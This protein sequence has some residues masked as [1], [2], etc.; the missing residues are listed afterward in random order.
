MLGE[1]VEDQRGAVDDL[2]LDDLLELAQLARASARRRRSRCR[3]RRP[4]RC[5]A[6]PWPCPSRCRWPGRA[7]RG[8]GSAPSS[9]CEPAVS[10][11]RAS[12]ASEFSA[13]ASVPVGPDPDEHDPLEAQLPVLDLGDVCE[14]G[15]QAGDAAQRLPLL[16]LVVAG[17]VGSARSGRR[18]N[19]VIVAS[20]RD[21]PR[22]SRFSAPTRHRAIRGRRASP[23]STSISATQHGRAGQLDR[24]RPGCQLTP[25]RAARHVDPPRRRRR[26]PMPS[27]VRGGH[28]R[29][30]DA[31]AA[32]AGLADAAL[33]HPHPQVPRRRRRTTNS[34][35]CPSGSGGST[36]RRRA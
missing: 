3:R 35:F 36:T 7:G 20:M 33:V 2:D 9:T 12:S 21:T 28:D 19:S 15:R 23:S 16:E 10:A 4:R 32:G 8:A 24:R 31:G 30:A 18:R 17:A 14:F 13:S 34:T 22:R 6:A 29:R 27:A 1:D 25:Q 11:S 26:P 5:R